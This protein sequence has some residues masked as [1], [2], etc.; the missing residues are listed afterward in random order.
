[1]RDARKTLSFV[2]TCILLLYSFDATLFEDNSLDGIPA[3][4]CI[5]TLLV[6]LCDFPTVERDGIYYYPGSERSF[7]HNRQ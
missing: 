2:Q 1:V 4:I 7:S 3:S 6:Q 5:L